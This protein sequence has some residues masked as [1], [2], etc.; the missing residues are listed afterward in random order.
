MRILHV[1]DSSGVWGA[2]KML[3]ELIHQQASNGHK[4]LVLSIGKTKEP[5]KA[6]ETAMEKIGIPYRKMRMRTIPSF[7]DIGRMKAL[8][9]AYNPGILHSHGY[10]GN[11]IIGFF[12]KPLLS[13]P[14][15]CTLH[16]WVTARFEISKLKL[17]EV[18]DRFAISRLDAVVVVS[19]KMLEKPTLQRL[20]AKSP[21]KIHVIQNGIASSCDKRNGVFQDDLKKFAKGRR[22]VAS[23]GRLSIEKGYENLIQAFAILVEGRSDLVLVIVGDGGCRSNLEALLDSRGLSE[24]VW[25]TGYVEDIGATMSV[26]DVYVCSSLTEGLPITLLEAMREEVPV[27]STAISNIPELLQGGEGGVLVPSDDITQ[28]AAGIN[29]VLGDSVLSKSIAVQSRL[30]F[31]KKFGSQI[32]A[33]HY[34]SLYESLCLGGGE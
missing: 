8:I 17:Y 13:V 30:F 28:L 3:F 21:L 1:I 5:T 29:R 33:E 26:F 20:V 11:V 24:Q 34:L 12:I 15:V 10:K 4:P 2:E 19:E 31:D 32:M 27:V 14:V 9:A 22:V 18:L 16:G 7:N 23:V 6:I 25:I